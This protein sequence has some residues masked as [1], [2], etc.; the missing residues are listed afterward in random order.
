M[1]GGKWRSLEGYDA[2]SWT[3]SMEQDQTYLDHGRKLWIIQE[4]NSGGKYKYDKN[5]HS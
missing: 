5:I 2:V 4:I 3:F 1:H